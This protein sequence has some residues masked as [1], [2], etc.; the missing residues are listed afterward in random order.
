MYKKGKI[1]FHTAAIILLS[2]ILFGVSISHAA[3]E[4]K[5]DHTSSSAE[6][7]TIIADGT[8]PKDNTLIADD[9][10]MPELAADETAYNKDPLERINRVM[11][12]F[13]DKLDFYL[14]KPVAQLYNAI[15]PKPLNKGIHNF[16]NNLGEL[17]TIANDLLQ[18]NFFQMTNDT[19]RLIIN[20][21]MGIG[22]LFDIATRMRL[23]YFQNDFGLTL[24]R[25]GYA[26]SNYIVLP[27]FGSYTIRDGLGIPVDYFAF[28][29]YPYVNP[30]ST[31]YQLLMLFMVDHRANLLQFEPVLEEAAIDRYVFMRNA[32][33]QHRAFQIEQ[34]KHLGY[35]EHRESAAQVS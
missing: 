2:F 7:N 6:K 32:Y 31:R 14:I 33:M 5:S 26:N 4:N 22:G 8:A 3:A 27:V 10:D 30:Q 23:P 11:F 35:K 21:T 13:N 9:T 17:P 16:F 28:S 34:V 25:W 24:A 29:V 15:I 12:V 18:L 19:A 1:R 20:S